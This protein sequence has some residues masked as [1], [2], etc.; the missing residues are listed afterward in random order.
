MYI[1]P[2]LNHPFPVHRRPDQKQR[3][4]DGSNVRCSRK[5]VK[6]AVVV[7]CGRIVRANVTAC[8]KSQSVLGER[9][10]RARFSVSS[11]RTLVETITIKNR[12]NS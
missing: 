8:P 5:R 1:Y 7:F 9:P 10:E 12:V 6:T 2:L 4:K 11:P 3:K